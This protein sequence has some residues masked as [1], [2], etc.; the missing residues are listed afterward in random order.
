M[1]WCF[2]QFWY[3]PRE[4]LNSGL[5]HNSFAFNRRINPLTAIPV[6]DKTRSNIFRSLFW[7]VLT[8]SETDQSQVVIPMA[9]VHMATRLI[10]Q[11]SAGFG[12]KLNEELS[13]TSLLW[14]PLQKYLIQLGILRRTTAHVLSFCWHFQLAIEEVRMIFLPVTNHGLTDPVFSGD[15]GVVLN[16]LCLSHNF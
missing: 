8:T 11:K 4:A 12:L 13:L 15:L 3:Q 9:L 10:W 6:K 16:G 5:L 2:F 14:K 7:L 1:A